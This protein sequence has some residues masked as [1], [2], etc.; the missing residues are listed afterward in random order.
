MGQN[1]LFSYGPELDGDGDLDLVTIVTSE[2]AGVFLNQSP[3]A[4]VSLRFEFNGE[5]SNRQGIREV[6]E[7]YAD[8]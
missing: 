1:S 3:K 5:G 2:K 6:V 7:T 4:N 8:G